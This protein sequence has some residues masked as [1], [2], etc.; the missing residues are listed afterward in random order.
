M[1][2]YNDIDNAEAKEVQEQKPETNAQEKAE[3]GTIQSL[4]QRVTKIEQV[5]TELVK[6]VQQI[7]QASQAHMSESAARREQAANNR[8]QRRQSAPPTAY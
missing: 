4:T 1:V 8:A 7:I 2:D 6:V 3:Q 5:V